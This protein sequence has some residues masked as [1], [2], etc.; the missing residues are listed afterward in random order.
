MQ[1]GEAHKLKIILFF[2]CLLASTIS[3][4]AVH[5]LPG[6]KIDSSIKTT[7]YVVNGIWNDP[8]GVQ[9]STDALIDRLTKNGVDTEKI[10][11]K[12]FYNPT[13]GWFGNG[14]VSELRA[15]AKLSANIPDSFSDKNYYENLG[16]RYIYYIENI[17]SSGLSE[18]EKR[19]IT[20]AKRLYDQII[21][22]V[23]IKGRRLVIVP[24]SQ[25]NF[26]TEAAYGL[27]VANRKTVVID[28]IRVVG[29]AAISKRSPSDRYLTIEQDAA[30][31]T[32]QFVNTIA[33]AGY[34]PAHPR[35]RACLKGCNKIKGDDTT[36]ALSEFTGSKVLHE[37]DAI[38]LNDGLV[39]ANNQAQPTLPSEIS[40]LISISINELSANDPP[41]T[42]ESLESAFTS[43]S[44]LSAPWS[45]GWQVS[46][47]VAPIPYAS[48]Q[49]AGSR[50]DYPTLAI[51]NKVSGSAGSPAIEVYPWVVKNT[52][53]S[54]VLYSPLAASF[55]AQSVIVT[56]GSSGEKAVFRWTASVAGTY[57]INASY[58]LMQGGEVD[59]HVQRN[60]IDIFSANIARQGSQAI[61]PAQRVTLSAGDTIDFV[62]G[63]GGNTQNSDMTR[64]SASVKSAV[65]IGIIREKA[66]WG[67]NGWT[68]LDT[69]PVCGVNWYRPGDGGTGKTLLQINHAEV[70]VSAN[71]IF[72]NLYTRA[73]D[74]GGDASAEI[75]QVTQAWDPATVLWQTI[76]TTISAPSAT[77]QLPANTPDNWVKVEITS[78]V[79][80]WQSGTSNNGM[81]IDSKIEPWSYCRSFYSSNVEGKKPHVSW[82]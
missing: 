45:F 6:M 33:I 42:T 17:E 74:N 68:D 41:S 59:V 43:S 46:S 39:D 75:Y 13:N 31:F 50:T 44:T 70:P 51:W 9:T 47:G 2:L 1:L 40:R 30:L 58:E 72:L 62:V 66:L 60:G 14:D 22:E 4:A 65:G 32:A 61:V 16:G 3:Q 63:N 19:V 11:W 76:P 28:N 57:E 67:N 27:L 8:S 82:E 53:A 34:K 52:G 5:K 23:E 20:T 54:P 81:L 7:I 26:Y 15:Q 78:L 55:P 10:N 18:I 24:H 36:T 64:V 37:F 79:K 29:V 56:P 80:A 35:H 12:Y 77:F 48:F 73:W 71:R 21:Y 25:G 69:L 38:Y 49:P